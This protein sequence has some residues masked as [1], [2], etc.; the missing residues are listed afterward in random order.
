[1][2][3]LWFSDWQL[4]LFTDLLSVYRSP[5]QCDNK[6]LGFYV[7]QLYIYIYNMLNYHKIEKNQK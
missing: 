2:F 3:I 5:N 6:A 4:E 1:M 7:D